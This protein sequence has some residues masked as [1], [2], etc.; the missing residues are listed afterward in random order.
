MRYLTLST[1]QK[2]NQIISKI[3]NSEP[4]SLSERILITKYFSKMPYLK[5]MI[6]EDLLKFS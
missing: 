3:N 6:K 1:R 4:V 5:A 2:L